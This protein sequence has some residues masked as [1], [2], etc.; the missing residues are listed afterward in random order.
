M[1]KM[2]E[3][4]GAFSGKMAS[5]PGLISGAMSTMDA[6][7]V[8]D[9]VNQ[10]AAFMSQL[11]GNLDP[12]ALATVINRNPEFLTRLIKE[13]DPEQ[14]AALTPF[15]GTPL[16]AQS[17]DNLLF[18]NFPDD[19]SY[20]DGT[21][22]LYRKCAM[23]LEGYQRKLLELHERFY[24]WGG[25]SLRRA[26]Q[27]M[28]EPVSLWLRLKNLWSNAKIAR[29]TLARCRADMVAYLELARQRLMQTIQQSAICRNGGGQ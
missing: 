12:K 10:N 25:A 23:G 19:W 14:V 8:A 27:I 1:S 5:K 2:F 21:H 13:L 17:R 24:R 15:P 7:V 29:Q 20:Y 22:C 28:R 3:T 6:K 4:I 26:R 18:T 11:V 9:A 16:F